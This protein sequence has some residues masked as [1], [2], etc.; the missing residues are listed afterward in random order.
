VCSTNDAIANRRGC[1]GKPAPA[2]VETDEKEDVI[3][4][5]WNCPR[6]FIPPAILDWYNIYQYH[7]EFPGASM[8][9]STA[10]NSRFLKAYYTYTNHL[11]EFE[12]AMRKN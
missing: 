3:I 5:Y 1:R 10:Q 2:P 4:E 12:K 7:K 9:S 11:S 8:L 6:L